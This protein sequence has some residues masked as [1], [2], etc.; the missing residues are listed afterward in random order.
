[1][2]ESSKNKDGITVISNQKYDTPLYVNGEISDEPERFL[3]EKPYELSR[4]E[5]SIVYKNKA[6]SKLWFQIVCGALTGFVFSIAGKIL[7]SLILK[8]KPKVELWEI[9]TIIVCLIAAVLVKK[10][11][12]KEEVEAE[13]IEG[14]IDQHFILNPKRRIH[15]P[16]KGG[17]NNEN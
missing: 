3:G 9:L 7:H 11:K 14:L 17:S 2:T 13:Q 1:M 10:I 12:T 15:I 4:Y 16:G 5:F 8:A 6:P